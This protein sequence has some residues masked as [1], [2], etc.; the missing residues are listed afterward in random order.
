MRS[1]ARCSLSQRAIVDAGESYYVFPSG[2]AFLKGPLKDFVFPFLNKAQQ[3]RTIALETQLDAAPKNDATRRLIQHELDGLIAAEC[4][5]TGSVMVDS[6]G[7]GFDEANDLDLL[8]AHETTSP[9]R[10]DV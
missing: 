7:K 4:P 1:D 2:Y 10:V 3:S 6:V 8:R 9:E 5:L